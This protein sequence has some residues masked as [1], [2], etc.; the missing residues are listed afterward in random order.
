M[1]PLSSRW[2]SL[3]TEHRRRRLAII[4]WR[5]DCRNRSTSDQSRRKLLG[6][7]HGSDFQ[8]W[9][10]S[11]ST[12]P[13]WSGSLVHVGWRNLL[14]DSRR[15]TSRP[16]RRPIC[17]CARRPTHAPDCH[18]YR[19]A[20][21]TCAHPS[22][23][24]AAFDDAGPPMGTKRTLQELTAEQF[25]C[26]LWVK[27]RHDLQVRMMPALPPKADIEATQPDAR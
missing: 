9:H 8:S 14:R 26:P 10:D 5:A 2:K 3:A 17:D 22:R 25:V 23:I 21:R 1:G 16:C 4:W 19:A 6:T 11:A 12:H 20:T 24:F 18:R 27:S 7:I 13:L 15:K